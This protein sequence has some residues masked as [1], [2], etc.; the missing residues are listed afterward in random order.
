MNETESVR[1]Q[2]L[3][4]VGIYLRLSDEDDNK[5]NKEDDSESIKNQRNLLLDE[6]SKRPDFMLVDEYCDEDLSGAG[7][8][9]PDFERLI[10]DCELG[11]LDII[12]C[13]S[14]SRFSRDMEIIEKYLHNKFIEWNIRFIGLSDNA[15]TANAGNKKSRQIN[16]LVNE[17]Y[18]EDVSNNIRSAFHSKMK[19]GEFISP[20]ASYG[21]EISEE[22]NNKLVIDPVAG[23]VVK[24]IF[25]LYL[26]GLGFTGIAKHLNNQ[27]IPCPSLYKYQKGIKLNIISNRPREEIKWTTNAIK[28]IL[29]NELYLG[30]LIQGKRTT[31][32]YKNRKIVDKDKREWVKKEN[33]HQAIITEEVFNK[34]KIAM[35]ERTK[36]VKNTGM[37][38]N[39]SGKVFC[40][41][42][43]RYLRK[44][45]SSKHEY[46]VC[47]NNRDGYDD[48][49][50]K[51]AMRYDKLEELVLEAI[52]KKI[53][54]YYDAERLKQ[55]HNKKTKSRFVDKINALE[56]QKQELDKK[57]GKTRNY[58]KSLYEDKVNGIITTE[59]FKALLDDYNNNEEVYK[60]QIEQINNDIE[61]Y[62][63]KEQS[64]SN[65]KQIFKKYQKL[66]KL[67]RVIIEE[68]IECIYI[69]KVD[70]KTSTRDIQ[71]KW[72]FE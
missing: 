7:T 14:Q 70:D 3:L 39:F 42:C 12:L 15:D 55:E 60:K 62:K 26:S 23:V 72:N 40:A 18:L 67:N 25:D 34:V 57:L 1:S 59:Q 46:L 17:W 33:M 10:R 61:L 45:N 50:N 49:C 8:Y 20:F 58:L 27:N 53:K 32:S 51:T 9:R 35:K 13:K 4:R 22:D 52:N 24:D 11:K 38:H 37:V 2:K 16:G 54:K 64:N 69:G 68:F 21:Y 71:I 48:C 36:P 29:T 65:N 5:Q 66:N 30:H 31:V 19:Q 28:T 41:E 47:S 56:K 43:N 44:K 63:S 6:I